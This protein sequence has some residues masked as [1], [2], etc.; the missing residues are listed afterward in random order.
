M[1][2]NFRRYQARNIGTSASTM[3]TSNSYDTVIGIN[4]ANVTT[5]S[6]NISC[7]VTTGGSDYYVAKDVPVPVGSA[8]QLLDGGAKMVVESGDALKIVSDT[9][10]SADA[11]VSTVDDIST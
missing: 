8:I 1:A 4:V 10:T 11:W 6:I 2:Q 3:F 5:S 7:Y 9:A